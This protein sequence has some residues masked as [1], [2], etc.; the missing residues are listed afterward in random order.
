[1]SDTNLP[2]SGENWDENKMVQVMD[3]LYDRA[4]EGF[5]GTQSAIEL[6]DDYLQMKGSLEDKI[7][8]LIRWQNTKAATS[9]F[10]NGLGGILTLPVTLPANIVSVMYI[11]IRMIAAVAHMS[12]FD[13]RHDAVRTLCYVCLC[14]NAG[15][16]VM[17]GVGI[18]LGN[19]MAMA[20]V[21][22]IPGKALIEINKKVGFRMLTKFG[23]TGVVNLGK[24]VP[25]AG[26][27]IG[28]TFDGFSTNGIGNIARNT[29]VEGPDE[30]F[31]RA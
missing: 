21:K 22:K 10:V 20:G 13:V 17:K 23:E 18:Q 29:F 15:K 4:V 2:S 9:G 26:G 16:D 12:G 14:G 28:A 7:N 24:A 6:G 1:M 19:K 31:A 30:E 27:V 11:Q 3:W 5:T 8:R 25:V